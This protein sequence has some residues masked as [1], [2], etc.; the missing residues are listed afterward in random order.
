MGVAFVSI[1]LDYISP[2][3]FTRPLVEV[4]EYTIMFTGEQS[5]NNYVLFS[6]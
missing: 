5:Q 1:R 2:A 4:V 6:L 3:E